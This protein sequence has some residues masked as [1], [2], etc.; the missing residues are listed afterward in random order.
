MSKSSLEGI[1]KLPTIEEGIYIDENV[2]LFLEKEG[3]QKTLPRDYYHMHKKID[4]FNETHN[5]SISE[6]TIIVCSSS[7]GRR[8]TKIF[9]FM[10]YENFA[11]VYN[12]VIDYITFGVIE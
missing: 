10:K 9:Y 7:S 2:I 8:A 11:M 1:R 4:M 6:N 5:I 12:A 3:F